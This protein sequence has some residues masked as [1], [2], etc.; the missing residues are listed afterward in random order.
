MTLQGN[1]V[2][3]LNPQHDWTMGNGSAGYLQGN[4]A[5]AQQVNCRIL[6]ILGE[7]FWDATA[8]IAWFQ[9]LSSKSP[10]GLALAIQ[11]VINNSVNVVGINLPTPVFALNPN[12]RAFTITWNIQTVF[13]KSFSGSVTAPSA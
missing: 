9:W 2:R 4:A 11:T 8:G 13:T 3:A 7:C 12:T 10:G 6:Q 1:A 5:I